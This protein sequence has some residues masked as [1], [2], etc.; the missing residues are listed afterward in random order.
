MFDKKLGR[1]NS[2]VVVVSPLVS[3]QVDQV[4]S[5]RSRSSSKHDRDVIADAHYFPLRH[6]VICDSPPQKRVL[7]ISACAY[8]AYQALFPPP[9]KEHGLVFLSSHARAQKRGGEKR[10]GSG[11][12]LRTHERKGSGMDSETPLFE[13]RI[14]YTCAFYYEEQWHC[15]L[16]R[17]P[18]ERENAFILTQTNSFKPTM[19]E[20]CYVLTSLH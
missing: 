2:L 4:R 7:F 13:I 10:K 6:D 11:D 12:F 14:S 9:R 17:S 19:V 1:D 18:L 16:R 20:K 3:L 5:L 15:K 8:S